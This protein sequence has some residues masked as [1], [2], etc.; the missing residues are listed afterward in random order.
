VKDAPF[1]AAMAPLVKAN[2]AP[3]DSFLAEVNLPAAKARKNTADKNQTSALAMDALCANILGTYVNNEGLVDYKTLRRKRIELISV[4][5]EFAS[6]DPNSYARWSKADK[7][8][9]W[10]N[11]YNMCTL[12]GVVDNYP[13]QPSR[14]KIFFYPPNS[15]MQISQFWEKADYT[16]MG[17]NY[18][19]HEIENKIIRGQF[20][21]PR[22]CV[23]LSYASLGCA[24]L[25]REPYY[26]RDLDKQLDD[27]ARIFLATD[28]G[29]KI[30]RDARVVYLAA[31]FQWYENEFFLKYPP[32][33]AFGDQDATV[34]AILT[35]ISGQ[36]SKKDSDW[37]LRKMFTVTYLK[38]NWVL[39]EQL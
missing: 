7:L 16:I 28:R 35:Y 22:V 8:A 33:N 4:L 5:T 1:L 14:F 24:P 15:V 30:D 10:I 21:E 37:L 18:S 32:I 3:N 36:I 2:M 23:A 20:N 27:Q 9:F 17:E 39:N 13:I 26:G 29:M 12:K 38:Y 31:V 19:L 6:L 11:A 34:G 25:R